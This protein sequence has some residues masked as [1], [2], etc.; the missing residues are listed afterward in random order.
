[1][2]KNATIQPKNRTIE[3]HPFFAFGT[4]GDEKSFRACQS[5]Y[6]FA[7]VLKSDLLKANY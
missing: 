7:I 2:S 6:L 3:L 4:E 1:M 5:Y